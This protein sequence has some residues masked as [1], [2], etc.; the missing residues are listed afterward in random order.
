[1]KGLFVQLFRLNVKLRFHI[2]AAGTPAI[3]YYLVVYNIIIMSEEL[4]H[5]HP[6]PTLDIVWERKQ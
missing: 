5:H 1:M 3:T 6:T 2:A 4:N